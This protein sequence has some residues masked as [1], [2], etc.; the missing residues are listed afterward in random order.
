MVGK[1]VQRS[2]RSN[3]LVEHRDLKS[4]GDS[5]QQGVGANRR[6]AREVYKET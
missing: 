4:D 2:V 3:E 1:D 6:P 5:L